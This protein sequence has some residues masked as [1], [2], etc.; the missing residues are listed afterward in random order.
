[1]DKLLKWEV[2]KTHTFLALSTDRSKLMA[3]IR[4]NKK[5]NVTKL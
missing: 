3:D 4:Q 1:M 2:R 5:G